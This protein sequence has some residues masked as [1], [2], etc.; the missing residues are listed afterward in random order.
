MLTA[1]GLHFSCIPYTLNW[2]GLRMEGI[3][4][5]KFC[6]SIIS[7]DYNYGFASVGSNL[8]FVINS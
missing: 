6:G 4:S 3:M 1:S 5:S 7:V 8:T 2:T